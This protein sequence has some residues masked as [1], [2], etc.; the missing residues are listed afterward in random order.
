VIGL[1]SIRIGDR[2][3]S[4]DTGLLGTRFTIWIGLNNDRYHAMEF[5]DGMAADK[6]A[7]RLR[8]LALHIQQDEHL[9]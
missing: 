8:E 1:K 5:D 9:K 6:I 3:R 7:D 4:T 2:P